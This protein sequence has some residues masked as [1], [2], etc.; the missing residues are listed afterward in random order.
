MPRP[1][2]L[3]YRD[4]FGLLHRSRIADHILYSGWSESPCFAFIQPHERTRPS[5]R[6]R[7][8]ATVSLPQSHRH[9]QWALFETLPSLD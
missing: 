7:V 2:Y 8:F 3:A 9:D 5:R 6:S 1:P 4:C